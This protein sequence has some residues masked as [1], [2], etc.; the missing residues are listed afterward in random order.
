MQVK[1]KYLI[2]TLLGCFLIITL[3]GNAQDRQ[4][5]SSCTVALI[6]GWATPDGRPL[7]WKNR[8]VSDWHQ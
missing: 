4:D 2:F 5:E 3:A 1:L 6:A 7:M 8:D